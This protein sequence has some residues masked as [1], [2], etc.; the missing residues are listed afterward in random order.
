[1]S[2]DNK[3]GGGDNDPS[4]AKALNNLEKAEHRLEHIHEE[5]VQAQEEVKEAIEEVE[6]AMHRRVK[7]HVIHVNEVQ[8]ATFEEPIE[9]TLQQVWDKSYVE[10]KIEKRPTDIFQTGG[11]HP[12]SLIAHLG[13]TLELAHEQKVIENYHFGIV[14]EHGGA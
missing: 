5:E 7:V 2:V 10:L 3:A 12:K 13:L 9:A 4:L 11:E 1:M 14:S 8:K 6:E